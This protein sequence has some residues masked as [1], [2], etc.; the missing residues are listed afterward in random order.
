[1]RGEGG[2]KKEKKERKKNNLKKCRLTPKLYSGCYHE[3]YCIDI[4]LTKCQHYYDVILAGQSVYQNGYGSERNFHCR[5]VR[6]YP[7]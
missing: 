4:T 5:I 6:V 1:M 3:N 7:H 2:K